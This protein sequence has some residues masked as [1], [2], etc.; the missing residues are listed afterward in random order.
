MTLWESPRHENQ[1]N[2]LEQ[3]RVTKQ[4][5]LPLGQMWTLKLVERVY[6]PSIF[7]KCTCFLEV[8]ETIPILFVK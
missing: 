5:Y 4:K 2:P 7:L 8:L 1:K 6:A 3:I